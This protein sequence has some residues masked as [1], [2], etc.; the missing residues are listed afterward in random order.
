MFTIQ[1]GT[2]PDTI[3]PAIAIPLAIVATLAYVLLG[4]RAS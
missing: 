3:E 4:R 1:P 2:Y